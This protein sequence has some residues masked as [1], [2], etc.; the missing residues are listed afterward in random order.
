M[1]SILDKFR[2]KIIAAGVGIGLFTLT[3]HNHKKPV[4]INNSTDE[5]E[6]ILN[7]PNKQ[8]QHN[9]KYLTDSYTFTE[10]TALIHNATTQLKGDNSRN[11][12]LKLNDNLHLVPRSNK[13][14]NFIAAPEMH[15]SQ[16]VAA[17]D[18][19]GNTNIK[20]LGNDD[21]KLAEVTLYGDFLHTIASMKIY[22]E[23]PHHDELV[24]LYVRK[25][26][27]NNINSTKRK[28]EPIIAEYNYIPHTLVEVDDLTPLISLYTAET[29]AEQA[30]FFGLMPSTYLS[31]Q[32]QFVLPGEEY[33][34]DN[35]GLTLKRV[36]I[37][38]DNG[39][40]P[41]FRQLRPQEILSLV[42][43][44]SF[45]F[46]YEITDCQ[47]LLLFMMRSMNQ[48]R[49]DSTP[50]LSDVLI[51]MLKIEGIYIP[52]DL[53]LQT[54]RYYL[55]SELSGE[56]RQAQALAISASRFTELEIGSYQASP[57]DY[58][59]TIIQ[60]QSH[61]TID[62]IFDG[63]VN[64]IINTFVPHS[65]SQS[66]NLIKIPA[67][68]AN[69]CNSNLDEQDKKFIKQYKL[70][71]EQAKWLQH[72]I[73]VR[74]SIHGPV[75]FALT[76]HG[77]KNAIT[78][79]YNKLGTKYTRSYSPELPIKTLFKIIEYAAK[80]AESEATGKP[81]E[82]CYGFRSDVLDMTCYNGNKAHYFEEHGVPGSVFI[83]MNEEDEISAPTRA[84]KAQYY[85]KKYL[86]SPLATNRNAISAYD[87]LLM[88]L[89]TMD[90]IDS[91]LSRAITGKDIEVYRND[92]LPSANFKHSEMPQLV[93]A[94]GN[95]SILNTQYIT[96]ERM[97]NF[98]Q[99]GGPLFTEEEKIRLK[100]NPVIKFMLPDIDQTIT[101]IEK[102]LTKYDKFHEIP[103]SKLLGAFVALSTEATQPFN[104]QELPAIIQQKAKIFADGIIMPQE[105]ELMKTIAEFQEY[106][107]NS[108]NTP[109][110]AELCLSTENT[111][112]KPN[113]IG[114]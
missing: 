104:A 98:K 109:I 19:L 108:P 6:A 65:P 62:R 11:R 10:A 83:A 55:S 28:P 85:M 44:G 51:K 22:I 70:T 5:V 23:N 94:G 99:K 40:L 37:A 72:I 68:I 95:N 113:S 4:Y 92:K 12:T 78:I 29:I 89:L 102:L 9:T 14:L 2:K 16:V 58:T 112:Q 80:K 60:I 82:Q 84:V 67:I 38:N 50:R 43:T 59:P 86:A 57:A 27:I 103:K 47:K 71:K 35:I 13:G 21:K 46:T 32:V 106:A 30:S 33:P 26:V 52:Q 91:K 41:Q 24:P 107:Y 7:Q 63:V 15:I 87:F 101:D 74:A 34:I 76:G 39:L 79:E 31:S 3:H 111:L 20:F 49:G 77:L 93:I 53:E 18:E 48:S 25:T 61:K 114:R 54:A 105:Q 1:G 100:A 69:T 110:K 75:I 90:D 81:I 66:L 8:Q 96:I 88:S 42:A 45:A 97:Q 17:Y 64:Q 36:E 73:N 56:L